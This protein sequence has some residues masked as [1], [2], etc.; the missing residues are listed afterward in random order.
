LFGVTVRLMSDRELQRLG[1]L[2]D[3]D[4]RRLTPAA[5]GQLLGLERRQVFRLL[6]AYRI[7]GPTGLIS[8]RRGRRSNRRKPEALRRAVLT[9]VRQWYW[10]FGPTL[11]AEKLREDHGIAVG[12]ETLRQWMIEA[13][14]W[15]DRNCRSTAASIGGSLPAGAVAG[16]ALHP[17]ESAALSWRT[18]LADDG[19]RRDLPPKR[20]ECLSR[21][22][23]RRGY[24]AGISSVQRRSTEPTQHGQRSSQMRRL[25]SS[26]PQVLTA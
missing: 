14:L 24:L 13:G 10:D 11:A 12:P 2:Q 7:E 18:P 21:L 3:L 22:A 6:K 4:R 25:R 20:P 17:L 23:P 9:I 5:A 8:K 15:R 16:W 1:V 19:R 26:E